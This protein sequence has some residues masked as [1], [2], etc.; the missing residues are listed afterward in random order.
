MTDVYANLNH[1]FDAEIIQRERHSL[2]RELH[3]EMGQYLTAIHCYATSILQLS[4]AQ[5]INDDASAIDQVASQMSDLIHTKIHKLRSE[6]FEKIE[7]NFH[8]SFCQMIRE[9][10]ARNQNTL[11]D[12][13]MKETLSSV[14]G[15]VL[16]TIY[17]LTQE[18]LTNIARHAAASQVSISIEK[19]HQ[20]ITL[21]ISDN[22]N[23]FDMDKKIERFGIAGMKERVAE[24]GGLFN[25]V[26]SRGTGVSVNI[27]LPIIVS[28]EGVR[29]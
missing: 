16:V 10:Q 8:D 4:N 14:S 2:A 21:T 28:T 3:D 24:Y 12:I 7:L 13:G 15:N 1:G 17:R 9:W 11:V 5:P 22:G 18:C 6:E 20:C 19:S 23:G 25:I 26:A 27:S 29:L